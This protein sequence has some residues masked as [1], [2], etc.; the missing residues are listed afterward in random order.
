MQSFVSTA[1]QDA[2]PMLGILEDIPDTYGKSPNTQ[3]VCVVF[4]KSGGKW[5]PFR[6]RCRNG[7]EDY[8]TAIAVEY[9][10]EVS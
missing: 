4:K 5:I 9:P 6:S 8:M 10:E 3:E 2:S 1:K 7:E